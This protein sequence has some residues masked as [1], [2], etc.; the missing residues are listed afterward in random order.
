MDGITIPQQNINK[1]FL[2]MLIT[3]RVELSAFRSMVATEYVRHTNENT[4]ELIENDKE[5]RKQAAQT[6]LIELKAN[7]GLDDSIDD[8]ISS[9]F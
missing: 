7:F 9:V 8:L 3:T 6:I 2:F 5:L 4:T 1:A